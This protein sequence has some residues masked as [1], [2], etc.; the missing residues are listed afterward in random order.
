MAMVLKHLQLR[1][2]V[3]GVGLRYSISA[4]AAKWAINGWVKNN[5]DGTVEA[6]LEGPDD[7]VFQMIEWIRKGPGTAE[8]DDISI[9][10][11]SGHHKQF[12]IRY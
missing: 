7:V 9:S 12:E 1:G 5:P 6:V 11:G 4:Q 2:R 3:Q 10:E 8:I